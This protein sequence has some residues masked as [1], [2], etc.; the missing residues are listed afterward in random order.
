MKRR[1]YL[2]GSAGVAAGLLGAMG[3]QWALAP[4]PVTLAGGELARGSPGA[5]YYSAIATVADAPEI[6][7]GIRLYGFSGLHAVDSAGTRFFTVTD[8]GPNVT[9]T[10]AG[11][12]RVTFPLPQFTPSILRL[13][14]AGDQLRI[15]ERIPLRLPAGYADPFTG[16]RLIS[17]LSNSERDETPY[18][19]GGTERLPYDPFGLDTEGVVWDAR[20]G[21]FWLSDEYSPSIVEVDA[22]GTILNRLVPEGLAVEAPGQSVRQVLPAVLAKRRGNRGMEGIALSPDGTRLFGAMQNPL[23]DPTQAAGAASRNCRIVTL[24]PRGRAGTVPRVTGVY[25]YQ[26]EIAATVGVPQQ[27]DIKTGDIAA[28]S[29][30]ALL[31]AERDSQAGGPFRCLY[32]LDLS[33][34]T[35]ILGRDDFGGRT[36]EQLSDSDLRAAGV[37]PARKTF[38]CNVQ[39][40]GYEAEKLEGLAIVDRQ[41]VA[42]CNDNDFGFSGFGPDGRAIPAGVATRLQLIRLPWPL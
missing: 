30:T 24:D 31:V 1:A 9:Q 22:T 13:E 8:R 4:A 21:V 34:A 15:V 26:H 37:S 20:R 6:G 19:K 10:V 25:V 28:V 7:D 40:L 36:L 12:D 3:G 33:A 11:E 2:R 38:V 18:R 39:G 27:G 16:S 29:A 14:L 41:T 35:N 5:P 17:G 32:H 42:I 23:N